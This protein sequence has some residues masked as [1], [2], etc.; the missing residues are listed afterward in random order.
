[1][2]ARR[3]GRAADDSTLDHVG[4]MDATVTRLK[5]GLLLSGGS[6]ARHGVLD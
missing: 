2:I 4:L 1:M 3:V 5:A 6:E